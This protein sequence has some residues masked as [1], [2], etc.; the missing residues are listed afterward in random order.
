MAYLVIEVITNPKVPKLKT[1]RKI[2]N[3]IPELDKLC[4]SSN[5]TVETVIMVI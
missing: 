3:N 1:I 5:P 2:V 4:T